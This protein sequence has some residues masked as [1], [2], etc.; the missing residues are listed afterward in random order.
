MWVYFW[1]KLSINTGF[2]S[3]FHTSV[4]VTSH[5]SS[6]YFFK[7]FSLGLRYLLPAPFAI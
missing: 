5:E 1:L 4:P 2:K 6:V 3:Y 7:S